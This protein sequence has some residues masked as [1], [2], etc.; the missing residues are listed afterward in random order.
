MHLCSRCQR[1]GKVGDTI[2]YSTNALLSDPDREKHGKFSV[3]NLHHDFLLDFRLINRYEL[4]EI[5]KVSREESRNG[6]SVLLLMWLKSF[7][8]LISF[9]YLL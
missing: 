4:R 9:L 6:Y 1:S 3:H 7:M 8:L 5:L 2:E